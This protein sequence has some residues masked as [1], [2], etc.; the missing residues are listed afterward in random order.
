ML[1]KIFIHLFPLQMDYY[2]GNGN[3]EGNLPLF[4]IYPEDNGPG[5]I[6]ALQQMILDHVFY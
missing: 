6:A 4:E 3:R 5:T 2:R 1:N